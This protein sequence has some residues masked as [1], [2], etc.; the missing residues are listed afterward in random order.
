M[1]LSRIAL[2]SFTVI[3]MI[4]KDVLEIVRITFNKNSHLNVNQCP[5]DIQFIKETLSFHHDILNDLIGRSINLHVKSP[6]I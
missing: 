2:S 4:S 5:K 6:G 3:S 1:A